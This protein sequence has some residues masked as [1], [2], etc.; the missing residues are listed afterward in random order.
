MTVSSYYAWYD[1]EKYESKDLYPYPIQGYVYGDRNGNGIWDKDEKGI[2]GIGVSDG[3]DVVLT[4]SIGYYDLPNSNQDA[5]VV[6]ISIPGNYLKTSN[7]YY[8]LYSKDSK[9]NY[10]FSIQPSAEKPDFSFIQVSDIHLWHADRIPDFLNHIRSMEKEFPETDM[11]ISTGDMGTDN[12]IESLIRYKD[13][14]FQSR[15]IWKTLM[16]NHDEIYQYDYTQHFRYVFGPDYY[17]FDYAGWHFIFLNSIH[18]S[19]HKMNTDWFKNDMQVVGKNKPTILFMHFHPEESHFEIWKNYPTIKAVFSGHW[20]GIKNLDIS[21][22]KSY[23]TSTYRFGGIDYTPGGYRRMVIKNDSL[24]S[25]YQF[26]INPEWTQSVDFPAC[27]TS[28]QRI[29]P[30]QAKAWGNWT[31]YKGDNRRQGHCSEAVKIP[32]KLLWK[33][34]LSEM[35]HIASPVIADGKV[36]ITARDF[37]RIDQNYLYCLNLSDGMVIWKKSLTSPVLLSLAVSR[38]LLVMQDQKGRVMAMDFQGEIRWCNDEVAAL[39]LGHWIEGVP[40]ISGDTIWVGNLSE[41]AA[42]RRNDGQIIWK[43]RLGDDGV[44]SNAILSGNNQVLASGSIWSTYGLLMVGKKDGEIVQDIKSAGISN[45]LVFADHKAWALDFQGT[46]TGW[47][48]QSWQKISEYKMDQSSWS[49][50]TPSVEKDYVYMIGGS[51]Q[52]VCFNWKKNKTEWTYLL[53]AGKYRFVPYHDDR[54]AF[55]GSPLFNSSYLFVGAS[56]GALHIVNRRTGKLVQRINFGSP[57]V[58]TPAVV[59]PVMVVPTWDGEI[60]ALISEHDHP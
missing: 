59:G 10:N 35:T 34:R 42:L 51:G 33:T 58:A 39:P 12:L 17:S 13:A 26:Y 56:D 21:G 28:R 5:N 22:I 57:I 50:I 3:R 46:L 38:D 14:T 6:F 60:R 18:L 24:I 52:V 49:V 53:G 32:L 27:V 54:N 29:T 23:N 44:F 36:F 9:R 25:D 43:K 40:V 16:G 4:D 48:D 19:D 20:H 47:D 30:Q 8:V 31:T 37:N 45:A 41:M 15:F 1:I 7:Y 55:S 11:V 2:G